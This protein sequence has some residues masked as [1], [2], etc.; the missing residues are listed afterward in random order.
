MNICSHNY[1]EEEVR[2]YKFKQ[3]F[4]FAANVYD[5]VKED[6]CYYG[7]KNNVQR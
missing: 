6:Y 3:D 2:Y 7:S 5:E 4:S 1:Y